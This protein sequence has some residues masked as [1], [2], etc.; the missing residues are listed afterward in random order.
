MAVTSLVASYVNLF[1]LVWLA[2]KTSMTL[3]DFVLILSCASLLADV[4]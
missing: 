1:S 4:R 3:T 2:M